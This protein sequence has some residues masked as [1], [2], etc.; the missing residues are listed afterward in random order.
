MSQLAPLDT[1]IEVVTPENI[2][3]KYQLAGPFR[4]LPAFLIDVLVKLAIILFAV[5]AVALLAGITGSQL[6]GVFGFA[7]INI[8][9]FMVWWFYGVAMETWCNGRTLGKMAMRIRVVTVSGHPI[10]G[11]QAMLRNLVCVADLAPPLSLQFFFEDAPPV[12]LIPTGIAALIAMTCTRR[13]QR[14]GDLAAGTMVVIDERG[15]TLPVARVEDTRVPAL[16]SY[17]PPDY[18]VSPSLAKVLALYAERRMFLSPQRRRELAKNL[19]AGLGDRFEFRED[20][21]PDLLLYALYWRTFLADAR[22]QD[23]DLQPLAG[24]S[25]MLKDAHLVAAEPVADSSDAS[26]VEV[27]VVMEPDRDLE[28]SIPPESR[29]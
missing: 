15:W 3:F 17:I 8:G 23:V 1:T 27:A 16:A 7:A 14:L 12:Y 4:R 6:I 29:P 18:R 10:G 28:A 9:W 20:L 2:A 26:L 22:D 5:F 19:A 24:Y 25:P 13:M 11:V 21:D